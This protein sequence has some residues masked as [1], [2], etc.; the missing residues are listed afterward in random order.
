MSIQGAYQEKVK[1]KI[2]EPKK[3]K[4]V[5]YND[6]FTTMEFVV[7]ILV[8]LFHKN[9]KDAEYIML[10]VHQKGS[11]VVGIYPYDIAHTK[12]NLALRRAKTNG[13]PFRMAVE[14][15]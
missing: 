10:T 3:Y 4:V 1:N 12:V 13:F 2:A 5:M 14:E 8:D 11:A 6:D 7:E 9:R 15:A